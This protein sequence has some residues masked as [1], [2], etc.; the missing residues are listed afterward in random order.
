MTGSSASE[1]TTGWISHVSLEADAYDS[2]PH[3]LGLYVS[4]LLFW[5]TE[6]EYPIAER[7][8]AAARWAWSL[9]LRSRRPGR[10]HELTP[11]PVARP[12]A[13]DRPAPRWCALRPGRPPGAPDPRRWSGTRAGPA[14]RSSRASARGPARGPGRPAWCG[15]RRRSPRW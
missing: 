6:I 9:S 14:G 15:R 3:R 13:G 11:G 1:C 10:V 4:L 2:C 8:Q 5:T 12:R 7:L